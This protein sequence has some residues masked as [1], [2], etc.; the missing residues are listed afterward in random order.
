VAE[1]LPPLSPS[2]IVTVRALLIPLIRV[3]GLIV[4]LG[5][6]FAVDAL[7][8]AF[9]GTLTGGVGWLPFVGRIITSP[10]HAIEQ[11]VSSYLGGLEEHIDQSMG[12]YVHALADAVGRLASGEAE[13]GWALWLIGKAVHALRVTVHALPS[14]GSIT[15]ATTTVVKQTK[16]IV[17]RVERVTK[18]ATHAAP[19]A[20]TGTVRAIAG[21]LDDVV[22]WDIPRLRARTKALERRVG[23]LA[24]RIRTGARPLVGLAAVALVAAALARLGAGWIRCSKVGRAGRNVCGMDEGLLQALLAETLLIAGTLSLVQF[25]EEMVGVTE[26]AVRPIQTFWRAS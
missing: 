9:F 25:A 3:S 26:A 21:T 20:I 13:A 22:T 16:V 8:R 6:V 18:I 17:Q 19:G 1:P 23:E 15:H 24:H 10:I 5:V 14:R 12:G 4:T 7:C 11:K 2:Q